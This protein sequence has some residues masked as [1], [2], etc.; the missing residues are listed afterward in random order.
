MKADARTEAAV[1][2]TM[3]RMLDS[4]KMR[5][6]EALV[7]CFAPDSDVVMYG[8]GADEKRVGPEEIRF[9]AQ[10]DWD[11]TDAISMVLS[12]GASKQLVC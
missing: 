4:Y 6:M 9:Q 12:N 2:K 1:V 3:N 5:D 7:A 8:T 10:R 11:Q